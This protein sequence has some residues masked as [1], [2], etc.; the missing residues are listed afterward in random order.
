MKD[1]KK[2]LDDIKHKT[3]IVRVNQSVVS[4]KAI[5][6]KK[7]D[8]LNQAVLL[9]KQ[10]TKLRRKLKLEDSKEPYKQSISL[11]QSLQNE[12]NENQNAL[13]LVRREL[14]CLNPA[15]NEHALAPFLEVGE[16]QKTKWLNLNKVVQKSV[17][18][19]ST[20]SA[21]SIPSRLGAVNSPST[22]LKLLTE[23][24]RLIK[25]YAIVKCVLC[26]DGEEIVLC[27]KCGG[28][29]RVASH[30][31]MKDVLV[32]C[33]DISLNC[34]LCRGFGEYYEKQE[35]FSEECECRTG[36]VGKRECKTCW[37]TSVVATRSPKNKLNADNFMKLLASEAYC[38]R[39]SAIKSVLSENNVKE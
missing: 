37:G 20:K 2:Q 36:A 11:V 9:Q 33:K 29:K 12:I 17:V 14:S 3:V 22:D 35:I 18:F 26:K 10:R 28:T 7:Q 30:S 25:S 19:E 1:W 8:L 27:S 39:L 21:R 23:A 15:N 16:A 13:M 5:E 34:S 32:K 4:T 31:T 24:K 38:E 6:I